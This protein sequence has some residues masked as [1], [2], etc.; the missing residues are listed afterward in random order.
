MKKAKRLEFPNQVIAKLTGKTSDEVKNMCQENK[1]NAV[2]KV[3]DTCAAEFDATT[4][5]YYSVYGGVN[6]VNPA[7][8]KK[9]IMVLGSGPIRIGQGIEFD[10]CSVHCVWA[11]KE[12]GYDTII[13][14]NNPETV[15][16][17]FDIADR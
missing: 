16:T 9:K 11:L 13:V 15:S 5:Y 7:D 4:P 17:D 1:I 8:D 10:Y 12:A 14:N 2:Y 3:V 6:E